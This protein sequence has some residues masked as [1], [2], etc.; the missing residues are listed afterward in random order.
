MLFIQTHIHKLN[1]HKK[2]MNFMMLSV[3]YKQI[4]LLFL[5]KG[6]IIFNQNK[7]LCAHNATLRISRGAIFMSSPLSSKLPLNDNFVIKIVVSS[8]HDKVIT[9]F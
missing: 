2:E 5:L 6:T 9:I 3:Q 7:I 4:F 8:V 1:E